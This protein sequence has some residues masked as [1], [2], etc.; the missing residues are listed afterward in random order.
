MLDKKKKFWIV[1]IRIQNLQRNLVPSSENGNA[2]LFKGKE[3]D[4]TKTLKNTLRHVIFSTKF[5]EQVLMC[6]F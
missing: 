2:T 1:T 6:Y 4:E 3:T 5:Y